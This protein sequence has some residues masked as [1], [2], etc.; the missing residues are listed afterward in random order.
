MRST[1]VA[2]VRRGTS[3]RKVAQ[4]F[5][6]S[7]SNVDRWVKRAEGKRLDR[8]DLSDRASGQPVAHNRTAS[9]V[10][11]RVIRIRKELKETSALGE[12]G[13]EA[14]QREMTGKGFPVVVP[15]RTINNILQRRGQF[16]GKRR[17]RRPAPPKGWYLPNLAEG[18]A[19]LDSFDVVEGLVIKGGH[20]VEVLNG[21]S[22]H[23]GLVCS[24]PRSR[25]TA[26]IVVNAILRHW[27]EFGLPDYVQFD[28]GTIFQG[29]RKPD[30]LGRVARMALSVGVVVVYA[31]PRE[32]GF[33]AAIESYNG[34]WQSKVWHRF[35]FESRVHLQSQSDKYV[36]A[37]RRRALTCR[38]GSVERRP[39]PDDRQVDYQNPDGVVMFIRRTTDKGNVC[40]LGRTFKVSKTWPHRLVRAEVNLSESRIDFYVLRR[41][42]PSCQ[43]LLKSVDYH[44]PDRSFI[45]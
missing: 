44:F 29:P 11:E 22:L 3:R 2:E 36:R 35:H 13:A 8:V 14:I 39:L 38:V 9:R 7:K 42:D 20:H 34:R 10:E 41:R 1:M 17:I 23:G 15:I 4:M 6:V 28:N 37:A 33:Q 45:E 40:L 12:Y 24:W 32:T 30:A 26:K 19:E 21:I 27:R 31:P 18:K 25:I 43:P 5:A 16:D